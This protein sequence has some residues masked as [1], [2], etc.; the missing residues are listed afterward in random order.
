M[1][2]HA[3]AAAESRRRMGEMADMAH[4]CGYPFDMHYRAANRRLAG[5]KVQTMTQFLV[6]KHKY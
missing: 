4:S 3:A 1:I 6:Q 5:T 2:P